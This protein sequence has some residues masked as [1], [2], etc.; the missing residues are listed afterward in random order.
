MV[1]VHI[2]FWLLFRSKKENSE[3]AT[4]V[5]CLHTA[6]QQGLGSQPSRISGCQG[7]NMGRHKLE[8]RSGD[9]FRL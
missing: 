2:F 7:L 9:Q 5:Q 3:T 8:P 4:N 6:G 1:R